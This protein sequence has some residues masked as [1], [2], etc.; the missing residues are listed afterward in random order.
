MQLAAT[1]RDI[2][3]HLQRGIAMEEFPFA[4]YRMPAGEVV[5]LVTRARE[6]GLVRRFGGVFDSRKLGYTSMLCAVSVPDADL[7]Q[8]AADICQHPGVTHCYER[9]LSTPEQAFPVLWFTITLP[10]S[11][12]DA[13]M[14]VLQSQIPAG[15]ILRLPALRRFKLDV[16]FDLRDPGGE[17]T[18]KQSGK[19]FQGD[20]AGCVSVTEQDRLLV[21]LLCGD[22]PVTEQPFQVIAERVELTVPA[23]LDKLRLW[24]QQGVLRRIAPILY[25]REAGFTANGMC[26]WKVRGDIA[27]YGQRVAAR[28]EVT[29]CY[30]RPRLDAFPF[31]LYAM[32][33]AGST[34]A[35]HHLFN[36]I[37]S[38]S[39]LQEG[40][41]LLSCREFKKSSMQYFGEKT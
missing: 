19:A 29:H 26:V 7:E 17:T 34:A 28:P 23:L 18:R 33:H 9:R 25:H 41:M 39:N 32:I 37:S 8:T 3:T 14:E 36:E 10:A 27:D 38:A 35:L 21:Q 5:A 40:V 1:E 15:K 16:V 20:D 24:K 30:Q 31:D 13:D 2:L 11:E 22:L 12:F 4:N 6:G